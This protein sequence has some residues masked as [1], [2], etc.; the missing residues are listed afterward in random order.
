M[1]RRFQ[2]QLK[3]I[4]A[5]ITR[6]RLTTVFF[7]FGLFHC[8]AQGIIQS[9]LFTID[10][11]YDSLLSD[12]TQAARIPAPN[13]TDLVNLKGGGYRLNMCNFIPHNSTDCYTI[14]DTTD[15]LTVQNSPDVDAQL[16]G[17]TI[18]SQLAES[19]F[20]IVAE[21][22]TKPAQQVTFVANAGAGNVT[23]S[24]TC[25]SILLYPAQHL[26]NNK[27]EDIAF[28][29]LQF[30][31][32]GLSV[33]AMMY[34][35][36][37]HVLAVLITRLTL[38]AWSVYALWRTGWQQSVF[39]QMIETPG[40]PCAAAIFGTYFST[41]TLYEVPD[42]VLNCTALGI[43]TYLS[44]TLLRTYNSEVFSY[45]GAPKKVMKMY[46]YFLALQICI[47]LETFVLITAAALWADQLFNTYI[48]TISRH[49]NVYEA[50][51]IFYAIVLVPWLLM[52]WYGIRYEKRIVTIAFLCANFLFLFGS[53]LMFWSQVYC[54][55]YYA[56]PCFG[57]FVTASLILLVASNVLGGV[58]LRNFDKGLAQYLYAEA[59][60]SSSN[61]APEVFERDVEATHVD[62]EQLK[63]KGFHADFTTQYL[64]TLGPS[65]SRDSHFSV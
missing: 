17:E 52:A 19:T 49:T 44:W 55:T 4:H 23:L 62:E 15:N 34:D 22:G 43:S 2:L 57:C 59:N 63:A 26:E 46:K 16:R 40:S 32:F 60:L 12:I 53:T 28:V 61:F 64:P 51:I 30:W 14:F 8:F 25:T 37:P 18:S 48:S 36:V 47:Q 3:K 1:A 5:R 38:S 33:I 65:I 45:I 41:R 58:C 24:E 29:A 10:S 27:R 11:Q 35:S 7:L 9:L 20:K 6:N 56:W 21:K 13:H 31:L 42:I 39:H 54:W 50:L